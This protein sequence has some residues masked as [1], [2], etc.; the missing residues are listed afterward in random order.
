VRDQA[1]A[2]KTQWQRQKRLERWNSKRSASLNA[3]ELQHAKIGGYEPEPDGYTMGRDPRQ[4]TVTELE[5]MSHQRM[6]A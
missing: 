1:I 5:A 4:M 2:G 3:E 6:S